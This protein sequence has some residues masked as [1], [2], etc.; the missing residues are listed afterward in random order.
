MISIPFANYPPEI[1]KLI[2]AAIEQ[3]L[4]DHR[5]RGF[6]CDAEFTGVYLD[7]RGVLRIEATF[8]LLPPVNEVELQL[9][10]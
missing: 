10:V 1:I 6:L 9:V 5:K 3:H 2:N 8:T 7:T 4:E